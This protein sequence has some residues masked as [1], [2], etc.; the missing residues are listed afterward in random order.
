MVLIALVDQPQ[1]IVHVSFAQHLYIS[2]SKI[3]IYLLRINIKDD[4]IICSLDHN[5][6]PSILQNITAILLIRVHGLDFILI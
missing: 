6:K 1:V 3:H 5:V 4:V 2:S